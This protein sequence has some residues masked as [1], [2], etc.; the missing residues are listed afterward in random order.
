LG[1]QGTKAL[2]DFI[3]ARYFSGWAS[4]MTFSSIGTPDT[5]TRRKV[6]VRGLMTAQKPCGVERVMTKRPHHT[7]DSPK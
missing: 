3:Y 1:N 7:R 6:M 5:F 4:S 2:V